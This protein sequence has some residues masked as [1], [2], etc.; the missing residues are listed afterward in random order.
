MDS[1]DLIEIKKASPIMRD[2]LDMDI[3]RTYM[4][5]SSIGAEKK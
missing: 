2:R 4:I 5:Y 1:K 3:P